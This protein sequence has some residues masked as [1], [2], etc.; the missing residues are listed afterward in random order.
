MPQQY[1]QLLGYS[2]SQLDVKMI[3]AKHQNTC[4]CIVV[5]MCQ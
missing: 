2:L 3:L 4:C 5:I 1:Y